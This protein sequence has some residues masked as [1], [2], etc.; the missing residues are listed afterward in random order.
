LAVLAHETLVLSVAYSPDG[1]LIATG[2]ADGVVCLWD[3]QN[4]PSAL[5]QSYCGKHGPVWSVLFNPKDASLACGYQDGTIIQ[6][7][8]GG[9]QL[10]EFSGLHEGPVLSLS[11][12]K[13]GTLLASGA[14]AGRICL[15]DWGS[16]KGR[17]LKRFHAPVWSVAFSPDGQYLATGSL[18]RSVCILK[19]E[20]D[21]EKKTIFY[22]QAPVRGIGFGGEAGEEWVAAA[23]S[24]GTV[25][26]WP[27]KTDGYKGLLN[28]AKSKFS[29]C[30]IVGELDEY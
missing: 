6:W 27:L 8:Q 12:N 24:D 7:S 30:V 15:W 21:G 29:K 17:V 1:A 25:K 19:V 2:T 20:K 18:D 26:L 11:F 23:C 22:G 13:E 5:R 9:Q 3:W 4:R 14:S 28:K 16:G 10:Q